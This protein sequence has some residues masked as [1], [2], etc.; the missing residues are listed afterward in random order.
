MF[1]GVSSWRVRC[2]SVGYGEM[3]SLL[4]LVEDTQDHVWFEPRACG[5]EGRAFGEMMVDGREQMG[6]ESPA[7]GTRTRGCVPS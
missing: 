7:R 6:V 5:V 3:G 2:R 4:D 1:A